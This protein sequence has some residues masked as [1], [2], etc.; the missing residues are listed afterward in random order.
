MPG[1]RGKQQR[2]SDSD[3]TARRRGKNHA[4]VQVCKG[5]RAGHRRGSTSIWP[6]A[7]LHFGWV[8]S[9]ERARSS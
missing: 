3:E 8:H 6:R 5:S 4:H 1:G 7:L 9:S 2:L